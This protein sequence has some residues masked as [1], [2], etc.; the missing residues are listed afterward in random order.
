MHGFYDQ[1]QDPLGE[2]E[3]KGMPPIDGI[4]G[5]R[6]GQAMQ[7]NSSFLFWERK[8]ESGMVRLVPAS[9][10]EGPILAYR[11]F[12]PRF[13]FS[14]DNFQKLLSWYNTEYE[15]DAFIFVRPRWM[16]PLVF[17]SKCRSAFD[18]L[19]QQGR[20]TETSFLEKSCPPVNSTNGQQT[21]QAPP[22]QA[23]GNPA[24]RSQPTKR[25]AGAAVGCK[26][27]KGKKKRA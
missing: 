23:P 16:W 20:D 2:R 3:H 5:R 22:G 8:E 12:Y 6:E 17:L 19:G 10:I 1:D 21:S 18:D 9:S 13:D 7:P 11:D 14:K 26:E 24:A 4:R 27:R 15:K 25:K